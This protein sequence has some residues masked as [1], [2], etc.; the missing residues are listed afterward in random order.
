[1]I[2]YSKPSLWLATG[3]RIE[4]GSQLRVWPDTT[5]STQ[6]LTCHFEMRGFASD[7]GTR[8][9][10]HAQRKDDT[11]AAATPPWK[12]ILAAVAM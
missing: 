8:F 2:P 11:R 6:K 9:C 4:V 5:F 3:K 10:K 12:S 1:M 7:T